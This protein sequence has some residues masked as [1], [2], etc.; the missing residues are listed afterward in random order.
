MQDTAGDIRRVSRM[1]RNQVDDFLRALT[2]ETDRRLVLRTPVDKGRARG[3]WNITMGAP[4][5]STTDRVNKAGIPATPG[6]V[7][8]LLGSNI[9]RSIFIVNGLPYVP[10][11][12]FGWSKQAPNG[13]VRITAAEMR[14][15]AEVIATMLRRRGPSGI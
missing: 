12:E 14:E 1:M 6:H 10:R 3:N 15:Q 9:R 8:A 5:F 4:D 7:K 13:M 2:L 11:L